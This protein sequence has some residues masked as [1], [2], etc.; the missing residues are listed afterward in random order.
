MK[1]NG[2]GAGERSFDSAGLWTVVIRFRDAPINSFPIREAPYDEAEA[3]VPVSPALG[4]VEPIRL[5]GVRRERQAGSLLV[6]L[7]DTDGR[8]ARGVV[9]FDGSIGSTDER[10][11]IRFQ[12]LPGRKLF[13]AG[14][15]DG[16]NPLPW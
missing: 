5:V 16:P 14:H 3:Q 8:P 9:S 4:A 15:L 11:E 13:V 7:L 1:L 10:G 6:R 2:E 12:G